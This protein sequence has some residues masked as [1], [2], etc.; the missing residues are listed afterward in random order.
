MKTCVIFGG[1]GY[2]GWRWAMRLAQKKT[3]GR[4]VLADFRLPATAPPKSAEFAVCD[5]RKPIEP[6]VPEVRPDWIF[7]FA[8][9]HREPGHAREEYFDT[10]LPGARNVCAFAE[11]T[12]C[13]N[14]CLA[15]SISVYGP[16]RGPASESSPL[17]P[18][19]PYGISKLAA[20]LIHEIWQAAG[21]QRRLL[22]CR[23]AVIYGPGDPGN[24]LRMIRAV[25]RGYFIFP[26]SR[27]IRKSYAYIEG[28]LDSFEFVMARPENRLTYNY[29][30]RETETLEGLVQIVQR[31]L[32]RKTPAFTAPLPLLV[33]AAKVTQ[34]LTG[35][36]SPLHP[37]RVR[38]ATLST[39]IVPATLAESGFNFRYD[40]A[41]SLKDW[42]AKS[43]EDFLK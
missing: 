28:L 22:V 15:S 3:F 29:A 17:Y 32:G 12:G 37:A 2:V 26:G 11:Q 30:E 40:F 33:A 43:P 31:H 13:K 16:T 21:P 5:V 36:R 4:I 23:P 39:H 20:E 6:Q 42:S 18:N 38:K 1:A 7:N 35:G 24:I 27:T 25:Q 34:W 9:V 41:A 10:N 8:A 14:I 19:S